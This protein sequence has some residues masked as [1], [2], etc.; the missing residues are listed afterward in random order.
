MPSAVGYAIALSSRTTAHARAPG[1]TWRCA[2]LG[3]CSA[4][5][6]T[7]PIGVLAA[8]SFAIQLRSST[9]ASNNFQDFAGTLSIRVSGS[10]YV[11]RRFGDTTPLGRVREVVLNPLK[12]IRDTREIG[13]GYPW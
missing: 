3:R 9:A 12:A 1:V 6:C 4:S 5:G 8:S 11:A 13:A 10:N 7:N 2:L